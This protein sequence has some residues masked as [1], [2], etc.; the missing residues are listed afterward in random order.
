M[1]NPNWYI[2]NLLGGQDENVDART[3]LVP[4]FEASIECSPVRDIKME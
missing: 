2:H 1:P 4:F 3:R